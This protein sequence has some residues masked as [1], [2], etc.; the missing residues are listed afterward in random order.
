MKSISRHSAHSLVELTG[1]RECGIR[2]GIP[3]FASPIQNLCDYHT[4]NTRYN[5]QLPTCRRSTNPP[6][7][8]FLSF[9]DCPLVSVPP[10]QS[11]PPQTSDV[12]EG[13]VNG[14]IC[15]FAAASQS[16]SARNG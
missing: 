13:T 11:P 14:F 2:R 3:S 8:Q 10:M 7:G 12:N 4:V 5:E 6:P 15:L 9:V 1:E 16:I